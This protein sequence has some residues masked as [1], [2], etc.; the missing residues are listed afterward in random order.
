M[1]MAKGQHEFLLDDFAVA[2]FCVAGAAF[3]I[4]FE[5]I[6]SQTRRNFPSNF[7]CQTMARLLI[8]GDDIGILVYQRR[9]SR[10]RYKKNFT[11]T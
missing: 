6:F 10:N 7:A 9:K 11:P 8:H 4:L 5:C 3:S 1:T 2:V